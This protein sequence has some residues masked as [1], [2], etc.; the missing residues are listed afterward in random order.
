MEPEEYA[1]RREVKRHVPP[2]FPYNTY[3]CT[4][5]QDFA[6]VPLHWHDEMEIIYIK[7]GRGSVTIQLQ[8]CPVTAGCIALAPPGTLH[9]IDGA[10]GC[11]M[12][13]ENILFSR[14][15]LLSAAEDWCDSACLRPLI[16]G[17]AS[18]PPVLRPGEALRDRAAACLDEADAACAAGQPGYP[19]LVK[20]ALYRLFYALYAAA[21]GDLT[22]PPP[23]AERI[24]RT[25]A[26]VAAHRGEKLTV[27]RAADDAGY[28]PAH[29][30]RFF[31][32][33]V[34]QTFVEYVTDCR[35]SAAARALTETDD[36]VQQ[37][38]GEEGFES[39][40]YFCRMF[41]R[42]YGV[43][44]GRYRAGVRSG[45]PPSAPRA[46]PASRR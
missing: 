14:D 13:Y 24:K 6:R 26:F 5:P 21:G 37:I 46:F 29:F 4:I 11:R 22:V 16:S 20:A 12:E 34:G 8:P 25:L 2:E 43:P 23:E 30:M 10:P 32:A 39:L 41:R 18:L 40:S 33:A 38:A 44:P 1:A 36:A 15:L 35:L 45:G 31:K 19:L 28:S 42:K 17:R 9:A 3:L 7:K 27:A